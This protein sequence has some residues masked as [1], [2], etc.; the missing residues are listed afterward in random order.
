MDTE[1]VYNKRESSLD[2]Q[3]IMFLSSIEIIKVKIL[4]VLAHIYP[5]PVTGSLLA[6]MIGYSNQANSIY[7][8]VL[9]FLEREKLIVIEKPSKK[10]Y[11]IRIN[12]DHPLMFQLIQLAARHGEKLSLRLF[13]SLG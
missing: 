3:L 12:H 10:Y 8:G 11:L 13:K 6:R 7:R 9:P 4:L 1:P 2:Y 5:K